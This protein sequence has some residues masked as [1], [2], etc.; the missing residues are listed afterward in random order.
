MREVIRSRSFTIDGVHDPIVIFS[1]QSF[2]RCDQTID[3][4][5]SPILVAEV[6]SERIMSPELSTTSNIISMISPPSSESSTALLS[7]IDDPP[8]TPARSLPQPFTLSPSHE[9]DRPD[10]AIE[11]EASPVLVIELHSDES[12]AVDSHCV[13]AHPQELFSVGRRGASEQKA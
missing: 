10:S 5:P 3:V 2:D 11:I 7:S 13:I 12:L 1:C 4:S 9:F 8:E 6:P